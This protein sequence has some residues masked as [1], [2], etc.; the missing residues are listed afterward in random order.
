MRKFKSLIF[1]TICSLFILSPINSYATNT[2]INNLDN[3]SVIMYKLDDDSTNV[4]GMLDDYNQD[5]DC[6]GLL[7]NPDDE[8][9]VAWL[10]Q[11]VLNYIRIIGPV[12]VVVL[13]SIDFAKVIVTSDDESM[14]KAK[15]ELIQRL[16]LAA[17]L[18]FVPT[19]A[20]V[21]LDVFGITSDPTCGID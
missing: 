9:S 6:N 19:L 15:K 17:L 3:D 12:L 10:L 7:G 18:F 1:I 21:I 5:Q 14:A 16:V 20:R 8:D 4:D 2:N 13:S 11:N